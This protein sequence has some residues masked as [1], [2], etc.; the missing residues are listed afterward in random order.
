MDF[1]ADEEAESFEMRLEPEVSFEEE[2]K[3]WPRRRT[4]IPIRDIK[5][6]L[7]LGCLE[8]RFEFGL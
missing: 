5:R 3:D 8:A 2:G 4:A 7:M 1:L 6:K